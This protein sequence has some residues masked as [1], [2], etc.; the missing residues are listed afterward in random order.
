MSF[1]RS[2]LLIFLLAAS[3]SLMQ[4]SP[5]EGSDSIFD[6]IKLGDLEEVRVMVGEDPYLVNVKDHYGKTP[7]HFSVETSYKI[8]EFLISKG[9]D[10]NITDNK[11][12]TPLH[13]ARTV[14]IKH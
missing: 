7:L 13:L 5:A 1:K 4:F 11:L 8:T 6:V 14:M 10:V 3:F 9:A 12:Q 2:V